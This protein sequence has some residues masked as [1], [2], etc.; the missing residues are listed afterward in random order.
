MR[1][2]PAHL[3]L[4]VKELVI[5]WSSFLLNTTISLLGLDSFLFSQRLFRGSPLKIGCYRF[6]IYHNLKLTFDI[7]LTYVLLDLLR[8]LHQISERWS[9]K[10]VPTW[11]LSQRKLALS[12][13][14]LPHILCLFSLSCLLLCLK[15]RVKQNLSNSHL[16]HQEAKN[17]MFVPWLGSPE[18]QHLCLSSASFIGHTQPDWFPTLLFSSC[19]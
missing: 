13:C 1:K 14:E 18:W 19:H 6:I 4:L 7:A 2:V 17:L 9:S 10:F 15:Q 5:W 16:R 12:V 3:L 8:Q 11:L